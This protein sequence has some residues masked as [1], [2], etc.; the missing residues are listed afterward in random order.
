MQAQEEGVVVSISRVY[1]SKSLAVG[2]LPNGKEIC[3]SQHKSLQGDMLFRYPGLTYC[4]HAVLVIHL[5]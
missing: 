3:L 2:S 4:L 5:L 1:N